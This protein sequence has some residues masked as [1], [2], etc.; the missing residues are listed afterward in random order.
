LTTFAADSPKKAPIAPIK[1]VASPLKAAS[2]NLVTVFISS[3]VFIVL[4][5][6]VLKNYSML[7]K[8]V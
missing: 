4:L 2:P 6:I 3:N 5:F 7:Y 8:S 1:A